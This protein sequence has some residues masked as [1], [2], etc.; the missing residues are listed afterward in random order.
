MT[1]AGFIFLAISLLCVWG[2]AGYCY[3][4]VLSAPVSKS[5]GDAR[6]SD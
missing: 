6:K 2:L 5:D 4:R 3:F 1:A